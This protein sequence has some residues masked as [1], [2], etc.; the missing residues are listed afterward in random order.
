[1]VKEREDLAAGAFD[2]IITRYAATDRVDDAKKMLADM[3]YP[4]PKPTADEIA[5]SKKEEASRGELSYK[6]LALGYI[7]RGP[8]RAI[9]SASRGVE[10]TLTDPPLVSAPQLAAQVN[11]EMGILEGKNLQSLAVANKGTA[12][13]GGNAVSSDVSGSGGVSVERISG[14]I[15]EGQTPPHSDDSAAPP[16]NSAI[17]ELKPITDNTTPDTTQQTPPPPQI[18]QVQ[19]QG[20]GTPSSSTATGT[21]TAN[22]QAQ[23]G[24]QS[25]QGYSTN[26]PKKKKG[27]R[28]LNPF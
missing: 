26:K 9:V 11:R 6:R 15:P 5:E 25:D 21:D 13:S 12:P 28:K 23:S 3:H 24:Q 18:N 20:E 1:M 4:I 2:K 16:D 22:T 10:P 27:L 19:E 8:D 14:P 17:P 7:D